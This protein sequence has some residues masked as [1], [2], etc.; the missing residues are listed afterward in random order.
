V[1]SPILNML[2][3]AALVVI[4]VLAT[5]LAD[6]IR[7]L[8]VT[9]KVIPQAP[10]VLGSPT[11]LHV[12]PAKPRATPPTIQNWPRDTVARPADM[13]VVVTALIC[14]GYKKQI[15]NEAACACSNV[16]RSTVEDWTRAALRRCVVQ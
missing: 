16:E 11:P 4:G 14:A 8:H 13:E 3:G 6:H 7:C 1:T 2:L 15:A 9:R 10:P 12:S 5:A